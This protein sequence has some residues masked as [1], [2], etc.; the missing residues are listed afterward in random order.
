MVTTIKS[1]IILPTFNRA[2]MITNA[3]NSVINQTHK[4]WELIVVDDGSTDNTREI[5][6]EFIKT[7]KRI[8]YIFQENKER[9]VARNNGIKK[10]KGDWI[11]FLDSDD[12]YHMNHLEE[13]KLDNERGFKIGLY[14]SGLSFGKYSAS[15]EEYD[16]SHKNN[17][18]FVLL[19]IIEPLEPVFIN[20]LF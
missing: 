8:K 20:Q 1:S 16:L 18:E 9:S 4:A 5:V 3:I 14:F 2:Q 12:I 19:N 17:I 11:C 13:F 15:S 6:K 10:A 7:D